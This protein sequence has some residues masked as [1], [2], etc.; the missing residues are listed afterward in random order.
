MR[1]FI[2]FRIFLSIILLTF[3]FGCAG[4]KIKKEVVAVDTAMLT[5]IDVQDNR[6]TISSNKDFTFTIYSTDP[7]RTTIKIPD[8]TVGEFTGRIV[9][10]KAGFTEIMP[11]QEDADG[12]MVMIEV[13]LQNP[14]A[15]VPVYNDNSLT[16]LTKPE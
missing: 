1:R 7:Y 8:M 11:R 2:Q 10:D 3:I 5:G 14:S 9:S 12:P 16:L 4:Q 6:L 15:V 13:V